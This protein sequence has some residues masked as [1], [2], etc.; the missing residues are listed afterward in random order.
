MHRPRGASPLCWQ[1]TSRQQCHLQPRQSR[2]PHALLRREGAQHRQV[3]LYKLLLVYWHAP[4]CAAGILLQPAPHPSRHHRSVR[5]RLRL[6][7]RQREP[8]E[9]VPS[10]ASTAGMTVAAQQLACACLPQLSEKTSVLGWQL[11]HWQRLVCLV[12]CRSM[13]L[14]LRSLRRCGLAAHK[15]DTGMLAGHCCCCRCHLPLHRS[16]RVHLCLLAVCDDACVQHLIQDA[17]SAA[18]VAAAADWSSVSQPTL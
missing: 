5:L 4:P 17:A 8:T 9:G 13:S 1:H 7:K 10:G 3:M 6:H 11:H 16:A 18:V 15:C 2:L 14:G 12:P